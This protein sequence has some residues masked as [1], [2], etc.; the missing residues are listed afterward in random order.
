MA[1][2]AADSVGVE[3]LNASICYGRIRDRRRHGAL[4]PSVL[5]GQSDLSIQVRPDSR[6][7][8]YRVLSRWGGFGGTGHL[9]RAN[10]ER[11]IQGRRRISR[12]APRPWTVARCVTTT[13]T[14]NNSRPALCTTSGFADRCGAIADGWPSVTVD[15]RGCET[16]L[17][18]T[19][20]PSPAAHCRRLGPSDKAADIQTVNISGPGQVT[21][22]VRNTT[23]VDLDI[24]AHPVS[25]LPGKCGRKRH[26]STRRSQRVKSGDWAETR[27]RCAAQ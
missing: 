8:Q 22:R 27:D 4:R 18:T 6:G 21:V 16:D 1:A 2:R 12:L 15:V 19:S 7:G 24:Q 9:Q 23:D 26:S 10:R 14:S 20:I 5:S 25:T 17:L 13:S 3:N 11:T